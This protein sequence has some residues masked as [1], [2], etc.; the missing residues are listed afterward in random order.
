MQANPLEKFCPMYYFDNDEKI[1]PV[2]IH[3]NA[4][5][6]VVYCVQG[7]GNIFAYWLHYAKDGGLGPFNLGD[8]EL[9]NECLIIKLN[10]SLDKVTNI[11]Y[12]PH[13]SAEHF[14]LTDEDEDF[15]DC[16]GKNGRPIVYVSQSKHAQYPVS[17]KIW[18]Y[19]ALLN[20]VC[21]KPQLRDMK[22]EVYDSSDAVVNK[23]VKEQKLDSGDVLDQ[24]PVI[25]Y[26]EV[27]KRLL[28]NTDIPK[29]WIM[30]KLK[31]KF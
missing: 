31:Q 17:G 14:Q 30:R 7:K 20:D 2:N 10:D 26:K 19:G 3:T 21:M 16:I 25:K 27:K 5:E 28:F 29:S 9:D 4:Q 15:N 13:S 12:R 8:H 23:K 18:R 6:N 1:F 22:V 11:I 24:Y